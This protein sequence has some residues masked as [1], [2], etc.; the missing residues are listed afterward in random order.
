MFYLKEPVSFSVH[1]CYVYTYNCECLHVCVLAHVCTCMRRPEFDGSAFFMYS[2]HDALESHSPV[3]PEL[4]LLTSPA[5]LLTLGTP[6]PCLLH[7]WIT[8]SLPCSS[9]IYMGAGDP[10]SGLQISVASA[11][12]KEQS[13]QPCSLE[14]SGTDYGIISFN[15]IICRTPFHLTW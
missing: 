15:D 7:A 2:P 6:G 10:N 9:G 5:S 4:A 13:S 12:P 14:F 11:L 1:L 8:S 3:N